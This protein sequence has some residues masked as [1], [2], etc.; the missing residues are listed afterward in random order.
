MVLS[1][2]RIYV[3]NQASDTMIIKAS[4]QFE[5]LATNPLGDGMCNA[6]HAISNGEIFIRTHKHLWCIGDPT[7]TASA[8]SK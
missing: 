4:P 3:L 2:D 7:R 1:G 8:R 5:R 6:S